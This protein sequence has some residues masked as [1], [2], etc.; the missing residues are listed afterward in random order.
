[1]K[2]SLLKRSLAFALVMAALAVMTCVSCAVAANNTT[3]DVTIKNGTSK[4]IYLAFAQVDGSDESIHLIKGW[5]NVP[6]TFNGKTL[7]VFNFNPNCEYYWYATS[8]KKVWSGE[9]FYGWIRKGK[10]FKTVNGKKI[11]SGTMVGF[12]PLKVSKSG[13][14]LINFQP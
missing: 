8:G 5:Y 14:A 12:R 10:A 3:L 6:T 1:M 9:D 13:K 11:P 2:R 4:T 7:K